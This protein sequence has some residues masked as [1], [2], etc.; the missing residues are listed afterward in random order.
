MRTA[1]IPAVAAVVAVLSGCAHSPADRQALLAEAQATVP[2][3][4]GERDCAAKWEAA[5]LWVVRNVRFKIQTVTNVLIQTYN[6][7]NSS[8]YLGATIIKEPQ[9]GGRYRILASFACANA[10]WC[11]PDPAR[12]RVDFNRYVSAVVP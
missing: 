5:Q 9:G 11:S 6:S 4:D 1:H 3:C 8:L 2:V 10:F 12:A 7:T